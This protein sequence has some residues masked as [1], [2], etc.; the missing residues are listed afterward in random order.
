MVAKVNSGKNIRGAL[1]YNELKVQDGIAQCIHASGFGA[2]HLQLSFANKFQRFQK[3][4]Q[5]NPKVKTNTLHISLNFDP[6]EKF[7]QEKLVSISQEYMSRIGFGHQPYLVYRHEDAGHPH[8]HIVTSTITPDAKRID[9]HNI[10]RN[11]SEKARKEIEIMFNL[12]KA[13][14]KK[15][16]AAYVIKPADLTKAIYGKSETK[17]T[18]SNIVR[19]V[20]RSYKFTSLAELNAIL[21]Q[22]NIRADRGTENSVM[23]QKKGLLYSIVD[24]HGESIGVPIKASAIYDKPTLKNLEKKF[25]SNEITRLPFKELLKKMITSELSR[26]HTISSFRHAL[27]QQGIHV[28]LREN[29]E[30]IIYGLTYVDNKN[31]TVFNGSDLGKA[32]TAKHVLEKLSIPKSSHAVTDEQ[33]PSDTHAHHDI[34]EELIHAEQ[35]DFTNPTFRKRKRKKRK[36]K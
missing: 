5:L 35:L 19:F 16:N 2:S 9:I 27:N 8:I 22:F 18:I 33:L 7:N 31:K 1:H 15:I 20:I 12:V 14:S 21:R 24:E 25:K 17:R 23:F 3:L 34:I 10:G 32:Y 30:G 11:Q 36:P 29:S 6:L 13:D 26:P 28:M 4:H